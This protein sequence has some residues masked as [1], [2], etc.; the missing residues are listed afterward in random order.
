MLP[1]SRFCRGSGSI[2]VC[3][4]IGLTAAP[5][6]NAVPRATTGVIAFAG[7][8]NDAPCHRDGSSG[9]D[10][11]LGEIDLSTGTVSR[12]FRLA[13]GINGSA[14]AQ[15][16]PALSPDGRWLAY[17]DGASRVVLV[18][19]AGLTTFLINGAKFPAFSA[20]SRRLYYSVPS[21][22]AI[23]SVTIGGATL[24]AAT[25]VT[26]TTGTDPYPIGDLNG[27]RHVAYHVEEPPSG[28]A[29]PH[30]HTVANGVS[31][32]DT[33]LPCI[34]SGSAV[35]SACGHVSIN[36]S[37][38]KIGATGPGSTTFWISEWSGVAWSAFSPRLNNAETAIAAVDS[39]FI[40]GSGRATF[41]G[42]AAWPSDDVLVSTAEAATGSPGNYTTTLSRLFVVNLDT[43]QFTP[44]TVTGYP[45]EHFQTAHAAI[46]TGAT[47]TSVMP[48]F[49]DPTLTAGSSIIRAVHVVEL[50]NII[51]T[52]RA[53]RNLSQ[54]AWTD[55]AVSANT[56]RPKAV[57]ITEMR[58]ALGAVYQAAGESLPVYT[59]SA[60]S[61]GS[62][63]I[64]AVH[65]SELRAAALWL[66]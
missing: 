10:V 46:V 40:V 1:L 53:R 28:I 24:P 36:A 8:D 61:G 48:E 23:M 54:F 41:L 66:W 13:D 37:A 60:L 65:I 18:K 5:G 19:L 42:N 50:R 29:V 6:V 57:H 55:L 32:S 34:R 62:S 44:V 25:L 9:C 2:F 63:A 16:F 35:T 26:A 4:W 59:D 43:A 30:V 45:A 51:D 58:E 7:A 39:R 22:S 3:L 38:T 33:R 49:T 31:S 52:L 27:D 20:D 47:L 11:Y 14:A 21:S 56:T 17:T 12:A 15:W 64:K